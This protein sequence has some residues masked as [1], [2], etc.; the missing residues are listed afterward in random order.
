MVTI[1]PAILSVQCIFFGGVERLN[2]K[3]QE[4]S[5]NIT[6]IVIIIIIPLSDNYIDVAP[7][8]SYKKQMCFLCSKCVL[9]II[10]IPSQMAWSKRKKAQK[11]QKN[12]VERH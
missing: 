8:H 10:G 2:A 6:T 3:F 12:T 5:I 11:H 7:Q 4:I 9:Q 1:N